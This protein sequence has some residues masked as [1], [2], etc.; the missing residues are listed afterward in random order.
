MALLPAVH[1]EADELR[2]VLEVA[3]EHG[4]VLP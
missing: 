4:A 2:A 1:R 3:D